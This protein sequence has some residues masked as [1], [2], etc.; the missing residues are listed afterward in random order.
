MAENRKTPNSGYSLFMTEASKYPELLENAQKELAKELKSPDEKISQFKIISKAWVLMDEATKQEF[1]DRVVK[2][3]ETSGNAEQEENN[4]EL[5]SHKKKDFEFP[6]T[7]IK[8]ILKADPESKN[9]SL[10]AIKA[11]AKATELFVQDFTQSTQRVTHKFG[12]K[13]LT[14]SDMKT[15]SSGLHAVHSASYS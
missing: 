5:I 4:E 10:A 1:R 3:K 11:I 8:R 2:L 13:V 9:Y 12:R 15:A 14:V 6:L 7:A